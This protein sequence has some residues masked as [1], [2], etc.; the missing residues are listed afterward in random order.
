MQKRDSLTELPKDMLCDLHIHS[1]YSH[2]SLSRPRDILKRAKKVG[3]DTISITDHNSMTGSLEAAQISKEFGV[4]VITGIEI[5]TDVGDVIGIGITEAI[6][7]QDWR[8]V[9]YSIHNQGGVAVF[10]HPCRDHKNHVEVAKAVDAI[11]CFNARV[12]KEDNDKALRLARDYNRPIIAASDAHTLR[13]I[14]NVIN[15]VQGFGFSN[16]SII[17]SEYADRFDVLWSIGIGKVRT[18][19]SSI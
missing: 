17:K 10:P 12:T 4:Q 13:E 3:L 2:D 15:S 11:E 7:S 5:S 16:G 8:E 14:G 9:V 6:D 19:I 1:K 18:L